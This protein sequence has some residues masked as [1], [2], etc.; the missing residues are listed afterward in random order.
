MCA[1]DL[2]AE[3]VIPRKPSPVP[4]EE[5]PRDSLTR[6]ELLELLARREAEGALKVEEMKRVKRERVEQASNAGLNDDDEL[7]MVDPP[8]KRQRVVE[9]VDLTSD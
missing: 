6:E 5:R 2:K 3:M 8:P 7:E 4:L 9:T 1:D